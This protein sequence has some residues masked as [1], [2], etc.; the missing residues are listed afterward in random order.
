LRKARKAEKAALRMSAEN[1][2]EAVAR[3]WHEKQGERLTP[4]YAALVLSRLERDVFPSLGKRPINEIEATQLLN[5]LRKVEA[6]GALD[7]AK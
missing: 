4:K 7:I 3:E 2:F 5:V 6:R 1:S